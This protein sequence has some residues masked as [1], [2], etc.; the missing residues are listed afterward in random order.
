LL[1]EKKH[2]APRGEGGLGGRVGE[3]TGEDGLGDGVGQA[4]G[5][6]R[7]E[8]PDWG[9]FAF[10]FVSCRCKEVLVVCTFE[11]CWWGRKV[12]NAGYLTSAGVLKAE[13]QVRG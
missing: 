9:I 8:E 1:I 7:E 2:S 6:D 11:V 3:P 4:G 12:G 13:W 10:M 5:E